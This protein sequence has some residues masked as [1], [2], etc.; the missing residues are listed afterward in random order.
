MSSKCN[1][2]EHFINSTPGNK[3]ISFNGELKLIEMDIFDDPMNITVTR[4]M[5]EQ[6]PLNSS[7][8]QERYLF[9]LIKAFVNSRECALIMHRDIHY[10][11]GQIYT[12]PHLH[13]IVKR[14]VETGNMSVINENE[15]RQINKKIVK[16]GGKF[17]VQSIRSMFGLI[18]NMLK[19]P[20]LYLGSNDDHLFESFRAVSK[21]KIS[22]LE[23][24]EEECLG[25]LEVMAPRYDAWLLQ[26]N[27]PNETSNEFHVQ[28]EAGTSKLPIKKTSTVT[29]RT[30]TCE[31]LELEGSDDSDPDCDD[32]YEL[33]PTT[34]HKRFRYEKYNLIE[35]DSDDS[36][37]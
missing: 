26:Y 15:M 7:E 16:I 25:Q 27:W 21:K 2:L 6:D 31:Q 24:S 1:I 36:R 13:I 29:S 12:M 23:I 3:P 32:A 19:P 11:C 20:R 35:D 30:K 18:G 22:F 17:S 4:F 9:N 37:L 33:A 5:T 34:S 14:N 28:Q 8:P 10:E